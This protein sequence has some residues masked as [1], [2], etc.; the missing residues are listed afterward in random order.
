MFV[1]RPFV[2]ARAAHHNI[3]ME[4]EIGKLQGGQTE[5]D[6]RIDSQH[7]LEK[8]IS[9]TT[10]KLFYLPAP[11]KSLQTACAMTGWVI[12]RIPCKVAFR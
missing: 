2:E 5:E 4:E 9:R 11:E 12:R 6:L 3:N 8:R 1:T 7:A 10:L